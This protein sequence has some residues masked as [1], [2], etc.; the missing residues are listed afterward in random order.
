MDNKRK[1]EK[2]IHTRLSGIG[3]GPATF[4]SGFIPSKIWVNVW[5]YNGIL[6]EVYMCRA[7][8]RVK[9]RIGSYIRSWLNLG[10]YVGW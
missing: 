7:R 1:T 6:G 2:N 4:A 5:G 3:Y 8:V 10:R 9:L